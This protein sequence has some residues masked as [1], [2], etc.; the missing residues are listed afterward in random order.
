MLPLKEWIATKVT[1]KGLNDGRKSSNLNSPE[2]FLFR[3]S[4]AL[5]VFYR[6]KV[7]MAF[8]LK[9]PTSWLGYLHLQRLQ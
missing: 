9:Y 2:A 3:A 4:L 7:K 8:R 1:V 5:G 6:H